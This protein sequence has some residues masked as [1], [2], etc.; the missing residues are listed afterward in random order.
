MAIKTGDSLRQLLFNYFQLYKLGQKDVTGIIFAT[1]KL[2]CR[3]NFC[4]KVIS[5][6]SSTNRKTIHS[7]F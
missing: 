1:T 2:K 3:E 7:C 4:L 5:S 6:C